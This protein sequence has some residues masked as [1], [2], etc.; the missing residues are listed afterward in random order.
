MDR[1]LNCN[2]MDDNC[3]VCRGSGYNYEDSDAGYLF[4]NDST[5]STCLEACPTYPDVDID[6]GYY[7]SILTMVCYPCP[8]PCLNCDINLLRTYN[9]QSVMDCSDSYCSNGIVC[10]ECL[11]GFS[12]VGG[13]CIEEDNCKEYSYYEE[14]STSTSFN[15]ENC[16]CL[17][18]YSETQSAKCDLRCHIKCSECDTVRTTCT[19]CENGYSLSNSDTCDNDNKLSEL[20]IKDSTS[21]G[22]NAFSPGSAPHQTS[23]GGFSTIWGYL[24]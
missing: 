12:L 8:Y 1:C 20:W 14:T 19:S 7:G 4:K 13:K 16:K 10:T 2:E 24:D 18:G 17:E 11:A 3:T 15:T 9:N 21:D 5:Y 6:V 23:C 22:T